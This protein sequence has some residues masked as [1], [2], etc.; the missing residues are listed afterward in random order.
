MWNDIKI[1]KSSDSNVLKYVFTSDTA[2]AESVLYKYPTYRERTV[3][4]CSVQSGCPIG[5]RFCGSGDNFVRSLTTEEIVEQPLRLLSDVADSGVTPGQI[6]RLQIMFMSMGEPMLNAKALAP[7]LRQLHDLFPAAAL[8][9]STSAPDVDYGWLR[10]IS[11]EIPT[12]GLQFSVHESTD[13]RRNKLVPFLHKLTL[14]EIAE[15][16]NA[17]Y[18][19]T[20]RSP[21][22]NYCA[23]PENVSD[24]DADRLVALFDP[25]VWQATISVV[26]ERDEGVA[27]ANERQ[28]SLAEGFSIKLLNRGFGVRV[29]NPA[30]QNDIGGGCGMLWRVQEWMKNNQ[31]K[32][33]PSIGSKF[34]SI[35]TPRPEIK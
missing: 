32:V 26:C 2:V 4:C 34:P 14:S 33:H 10:D 19:A 9:I 21:F 15:Q 13:E 7:A 22:F 27:A 16:G 20:G 1:I 8:L 25:S 35:H 23:Q 17:W 24:A 31:D 28:R 30:G 3:I 11:V 6:G 5:C 18:K 29:F 12:V